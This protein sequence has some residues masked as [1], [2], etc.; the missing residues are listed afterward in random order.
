MFKYLA[1]GFVGC[2]AVVAGIWLGAFLM[3]PGAPGEE[4]E[5]H[6]E[7]SQVS[8]DINGIPVVQNGQV[9]GYFVIKVSSVID[10]N[11]VYW[12]VEDLR[13]PL[14]DAAIRAVADFATNGIQQINSVQMKSLTNA[15]LAN[16]AANIG[17]NAVKAVHVEQFNYVT[18]AQVR[19]NLFKVN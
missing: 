10:R 1:A 18:K 15:I 11:S 16:A 4:A 13:P 19:E 2:V 6:P 14:M 5:R 12:P 8:S 17:E 9:V 3:A 7:F